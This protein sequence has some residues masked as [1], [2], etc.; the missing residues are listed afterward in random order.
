[1]KTSGFLEKQGVVFFIEYN[2]N[3]PYE[4]MAYYAIKSFKYFNPEI[5]VALIYINDKKHIIE[6]LLEKECDYLINIDPI[7]DNFGKNKKISNL[8]QLYWA[9]PFE[10]NIYFDCDFLFTKSIREFFSNLSNASLCFSNNSL[11][12]RS[13]IKNID[14]KFHFFYKQEIPF[15]NNQVFMF[16]KDDI[17][18]EFFNLWSQISN[19]YQI[20]YNEFLKNPYDVQD[21][22]IDIS[23]ALKLSDNSQFIKNNLYKWID[24][25][26]RK[27]HYT[28][29]ENKDFYKYVNLWCVNGSRFKFENYFLNYP[30]HYKNHGFLNDVFCNYF[31]EYF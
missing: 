30:I 16:K 23:L 12:F 6:N 25:R 27:I 10:E 20:F 7:N 14:Y 13:N 22:K 5:S 11:D 1:M 28:D 29:V 4:K 8:Y 21:I 2:E 18:L 9:S 17:S 19:N 26:P 15:V 24:L 3:I 31:E